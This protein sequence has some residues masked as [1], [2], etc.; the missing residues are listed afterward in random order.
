MTQYLKF[1]KLA[2][3]LGVILGT[4]VFAGSAS[5]DTGMNVQY[6]NQDA[7]HQYPGK[8][9]APL[10]VR[11][12]YEPA[13]ADDPNAQYYP[14]LSSYRWSCDGGYGGANQ[15][16]STGPSVT[17]YYGVPGSHDVRLDGTGPSGLY[18]LDV[19]VTA[20]A[21]DDIHQPIRYIGPTTL[22]RSTVWGIQSVKPI[23]NAGGDAGQGGFFVDRAKCPASMP[24]GTRCFRLGPNS[25]T[26][27]SVLIDA[28]A[29]TPGSDENMD[30]VLQRVQV[31]PDPVKV[32]TTRF[33]MKRRGRCTYGGKINVRTGVAATAMV[34]VTLQMRLGRGKWKTVGHQRQTRH[35]NPSVSTTK[36]QVRYSLTSGKVVGAAQ[37]RGARFRFVYQGRVA[38]GTLK[39]YDSRR[40]TVGLSPSQVLTCGL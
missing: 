34:D 4:L 28:E 33:R 36:A 5:A 24:A 29:L 37:R 23:V 35:Y 20:L 17:C 27:R 19:G 16:D 38:D 12:T 9:V 31:L 22:Y 2:V 40:R 8:A 39:Y 15:T 14:P 25:P 10:S 3:L 30:K 1:S 18:R 11:V 21:P 6:L 26:R 32:T 13:P 7:A